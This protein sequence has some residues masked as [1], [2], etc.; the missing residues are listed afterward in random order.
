MLLKEIFEAHY[1]E[2]GNLPDEWVNNMEITKRSNVEQVVEKMNFQIGIELVKVVVLGASDKRYIPIHKR[3]FEGIFER[4]IQMV[5]FDIDP[6]HLGGES[7]EVIFH[8]ITKPF[9]N[10]P[11]DVIFS[12]ELMKFL[13]PEEQLQTIKNSYEA[14][15][16]NGFA[17]HIMHEPSIKGTS[18]LRSWQTRV[19]P[20]ELVDQLILAKVPAVKLILSSESQ[21]SWLRET[22]VIAFKKF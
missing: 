7:S 18:E 4:Q 1:I 16:T 20:D 13:T 9:P 17:M 15:S 11:Y 19:N 2:Y 10:I 5:T 21:V 3:I 8:D 22:T 6:E 14:L 12:H